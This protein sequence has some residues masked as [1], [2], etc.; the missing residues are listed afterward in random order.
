MPDWV[1]SL[2]AILAALLAVFNVVI[3]LAALGVIPGNR[4]PSTGMAWLI[5]ILAVPLLGFVAFLFFG[6]TR[7]DRHRHEKQRQVNDEI[8]ARTAAVAALTESTPRL[9]Y[10]SS[11][12]LLN[13]NLGAL[14]G[15]GGNHVVFFEDY[16][17]SI[18]AMA[19]EVDT[20]REFVHVQF[21]ITA[22]D[23]VT[24]PFFAAL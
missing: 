21:Y 19:A 16:R 2:P 22:W 20:A 8:H 13:R 24:E 18:A 11:V 5:L 10:V 4:K 6:S 3:C 12:A 14:P 9:A 17:E 1:H 23:D 7:V 15:V